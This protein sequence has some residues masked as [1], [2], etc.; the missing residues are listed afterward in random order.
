LAIEREAGGL[1]LYSTLIEAHGRYEVAQLEVQRLR[2]DVLPRLARAETA[3]EGA[4]R[5]GAVSY[6]EWAQLQSEQTDVRRRQ[7]DAAIDG[8]RVLIEI[9][10]LTGQPFVAGPATERGTQP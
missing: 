4:Y 8:Q 10:R 1:A 9:Q 3:A 5:A 2:D 7:L 6:L